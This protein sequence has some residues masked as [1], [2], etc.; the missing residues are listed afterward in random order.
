MIIHISSLLLRAVALAS[1]KQDIRQY[2]NG[3]LIEVKP[4]GVFLVATDGHRMHVAVTDQRPQDAPEFNLIVPRA[5]VALAAKKYGAADTPLMLSKDQTGPWSLAHE[6]FEPLQGTFPE[7]RR[8]VPE[9]AANAR[10]AVPPLNAKYVDDLANAAVLLGGKHAG[11]HLHC[12]DGR[13]VLAK[14]NGREDFFAI[15]MGQNETEAIKKD[16][17]NPW[18]TAATS[19]RPVWVY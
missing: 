4:K 14:L 17:A 3:V 6:P 10:V 15:L 16:P 1:A 12:C 7:W 9:M 19:A 11:F 13:T 2:L 5:T 18:H 8:V